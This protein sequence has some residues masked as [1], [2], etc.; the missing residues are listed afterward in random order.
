MTTVA[1]SLDQPNGAGLCALHLAA[2]KGEVKAIKS[3]L[4]LGMHLK[5]FPS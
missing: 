3:L 4:A 2:E 5:A 1:N